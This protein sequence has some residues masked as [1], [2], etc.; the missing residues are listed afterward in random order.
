MSLNKII[1]I[2][3][4][5]FILIGSL[6][7]TCFMSASLTE[8]QETPFDDLNEDN[9]SLVLQALKSEYVTAYENTYG[10]AL[11]PS[12]F[13]FIGVWDYSG[14]ATYLD[15]DITF[16]LY[17]SSTLLTQIPI[18]RYKDSINI[19]VYHLDEFGKAKKIDNGTKTVLLDPA[20]FEG[21]IQGIQVT[22][23]NVNYSLNED[24]LLFFV[25]EIDQSEKLINNYVAKQYEDKLKPLAGRIADFLN[26][27]K[28]ETISEIGMT[29]NEMLDILD[30]A[31]I[32]GKDIGDLANVLRSSAFYY[33]SDSHSSKIKFSTADNESYTLYFQNNFSDFDP[34]FKVINETKPTSSTEH[35][36]PPIVNPADLKLAE[37]GE[38]INWFL[39]WIVFN[40]ETSSNETE[41]NKIVYYL[42][43]NE[44]MNTA[45]PKESSTIREKLSDSALKFTGPKITRNIIIKNITVDLYIQYSKLLTLR[46]PTIKVSIFDNDKE[47]A[48]SEIKIDRAKLTELLR[49]GADSPTT[50]Y[51]NLNDQIFYNHHIR[52][53]VTGDKP[54]LVLKPLNLLY[55]SD[56]YPS[57]VTIYYN[58]TENIKVDGVGDKPISIYAGGSAEYDLTIKSRYEDKINLTVTE[59][60][61]EFEVYYY[62]K[63]FSIKENGSAKAHVFVNSTATDASAYG[64]KVQVYFNLSGNTG[65]TS[66]KSEV[67]VSE[68]A[69]VH[70]IIVIVKGCP[71]IKHGQTKNLT[72]II[73][74]NNT[75]YMKDSYLISVI[76][77]HNLSLNNTEL[78]GYLDVYN[79]SVKGP[80]AKVNVTISVPWYTDIKSDKITFIIASEHSKQKYKTIVNVTINIEGPNIFESTYHI[81]ESAADEMGL[82]DELDGYGTFLLIFIIFFLIAFFVILAIILARRK[83]VELI[84][85]D[86][87]KE[88]SPDETATYEM[89]LRNPCKRNMTYDVFVETKNG[90]TSARWEVSLD[91]T[92]LYLEPHK[93][94]A[95]KLTVKPSNYVKK[96]DWIEVK[97][98]AKPIG[99]NKTADI[100]TVTTLKDQKL[101]LKI[102]GVIHWPRIFKEGDKVETS[103]KLTNRGNVSAENVTVILFVNGKEKN[104][105]ENINIPRGG[106]ADIEIPWI[107]GKGK[108]EVNIVVK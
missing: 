10:E 53:E 6:F 70:D 88:I 26:N 18:E 35:S 5:I 16:D 90:D 96:D 108:N 38:W 69:I 63:E 37:N 29:T 80:E 107:A 95:L 72:F 47:L 68:D 64:D 77:E 20:L 33:G 36:F 44:E 40:V 24:D 52:L 39:L 49:R 43:E 73:R 81:F 105:V 71:K 84:C 87:V 82:N 85:L 27:S 76:S 54:M 86:R 14:N 66:K 60:S 75:G 45:K 106:F 15:G 83:Y 28:N 103:F 22:L 48:S 50:I 41:I 11:V 91:K 79:E 92:R 78:E 101:N 55:N 12:P 51:F 56:Q 104:R 67:E 30:E 94:D 21:R 31:G 9:I 7:S 23:K 57:S 13:R 74:N 2:N 4:I 62:P 59:N 93:S 32:T 17:F 61:T 34:N 100:A 19:S 42:D 99:K 8:A 58:E 97:V 102:S 1:K 65:F 98:I 46:K 25:I 3:I 89:T